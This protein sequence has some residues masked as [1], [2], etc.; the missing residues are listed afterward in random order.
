MTYM[1][2]EER[3]AM[4]RKR[5]AFLHEIATQYSSI[6]AFA[7]EKDEWFAV[8]GI[9]LTHCEEYISLYIPLGFNEYETYHVINGNDGLLDISEVICWQ[10]PYCF[11]DVINIFTR[12]SVSEE[13][14][15]TSIHDYSYPMSRNDT[16]FN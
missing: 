5:H 14:I 7:S 13:E 15:L 16:G 2:F 3:Y 6:E 11:N 4:M 10:D 1:T 12:E 8:R 9:E